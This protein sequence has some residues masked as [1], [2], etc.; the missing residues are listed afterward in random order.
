PAV[1]APVVVSAAPAPAVA[2]PVVVSAAPAPAVAAQAVAVT[3]PVAP[4]ADTAAL[5]ASMPPAS[6]SAAVI[7][8]PTVAE[9]LAAGPAVVPAAPSVSIPPVRPKPKIMVDSAPIQDRVESSS[10]KGGAHGVPFAPLQPN[11]AQPTIPHLDGEVLRIVLPLSAQNPVK[12]GDIA[13]IVLPLPGGGDQPPGKPLPGSRGQLPGKPPTGSGGQPP[14]KPLPGSGDQPPGKPRA[15]KRAS[16]RPTERMVRDPAPLPSPVEERLEVK[17]VRREERSQRVQVPAFEV[18]AKYTAL[19]P[20]IF[21]PQSDRMARETSTLLSAGA[22]LA[23]GKETATLLSSGAKLATGSVAKET[24]TLFAP[25]VSLKSS[26]ATRDEL[27]PVQAGVAPVRDQGHMSPWFATPPGRER[28]DAPLPGGAVPGRERIVASLPGGA[29][30]GQGRVD[31]PLPR[32]AVLSREEP[33]ISA[34]P[35][36]VVPQPGVAAQVAKPV[37]EK[38]GPDMI[39][40]VHHLRQNVALHDWAVGVVSPSGS[41]EDGPEPWGTLL[42]NFGCKGEGKTGSHLP[43]DQSTSSDLADAR[44]SSFPWRVV[45]VSSDGVTESAPLHPE[46]FGSEFPL[47]DGQNVGRGHASERTYQKRTQSLLPGSLQELGKFAG[48][49]SVEGSTWDLALKKTFWKNRFSD[50]SELGIKHRENSFKGSKVPY[51]VRGWPT[52][53]AGEFLAGP[54]AALWR[55]HIA[56]GPEAPYVLARVL[57]APDVRQLSPSSMSAALTSAFLAERLQG[58][59]GCSMVHAPFWTAGRGV[60]PGRAVAHACLFRD[61]VVRGRKLW[62]TVGSVWGRSQGDGGEGRGLSDVATSSEITSEEVVAPAP[63]LPPA[64]EKVVASVPPPAVEEVVALAP[65]PMAAIARPVWEPV[66]PVAGVGTDFAT[67]D[68][69]SGEP[70]LNAMAEHGVVS[71]AAD[72]EPSTHDKPLSVTRDELAT[73]LLLTHQPQ[74]ESGV[75]GAVGVGLEQESDLMNTG[76]GGVSGRRAPFEGRGSF[77]P[78]AK[79]MAEMEAFHAHPAV[80]RTVRPPIKQTIDRDDFHRHP[81]V[82]NTALPPVRQTT[83]KKGFHPRPASV[84]SVFPP[85]EYMA[86]PEVIKTAPPSTAKR[87]AERRELHPQPRAV[88]PGP[89]PVTYVVVQDAQ[90]AKAAR[91]KS[92]KRVVDTS[93][94]AVP[95]ESL[96]SG[97]ANLMGDG[98]EYVVNLFKRL[99]GKG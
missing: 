36:F 52:M 56:P 5:S 1:A 41:E 44:G 55:H 76:H 69:Q 6:R 50:Q 40:L 46:A 34:E 11:I 24:A 73:P 77:S 19:D 38:R 71:M 31:A 87:L 63:A 28:I 72:A 58:G 70:V 91:P 92:G 94:D 64:V 85:A 82:V 37:T 62:S 86:R 45:P 93:V 97:F 4:L 54:F 99:L 68:L 21:R 74:L 96:G 79:Q 59:L 80:V 8:A 61:T 20:A 22:R 26:L 67:P 13:E 33:R 51:L 17:A 98:V 16:A 23:T 81:A 39:H 18:A 89:G 42:V 29:V 30:P 75:D 83:D 2:A 9:F 7:V 48:K 35:A 49:D 32:G 90:P 14:G 15:G 60:C 65:P 43:T 84:K 25:K 57:A 88:G 3:S 12:L 10:R 47:P 66:A 53:Y 27:P 95:V 78:S